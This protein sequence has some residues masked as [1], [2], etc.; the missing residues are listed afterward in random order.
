MLS[1]LTEESRFATFAWFATWVL[2]HGAWL[3]ITIGEAVR[4]RVEPTD[5][6]I[7]ESAMVKT[8]SPLSIYNNLGDVQAWVFGFREFTE[9]W[10]AFAILSAITIV[11][12]LVLYR[13][14]DA[15]LRA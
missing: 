7:A 12:L 1:S 11:S 6:L 3:A 15:P 14:V 5:P 9:I 8:W 2:G 10:P 13:R 4:Y